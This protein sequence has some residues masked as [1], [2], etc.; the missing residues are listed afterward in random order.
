MPD[1]KKTEQS[2]LALPVPLS[3]PEAWHGG[4]EGGWKGTGQGLP[5]TPLLTQLVP[6]LSPGQGPAGGLCPIP[7]RPDWVETCLSASSSCSSSPAPRS[8]VAHARGVQQHQRA[9]SSQ[10]FLY[11]LMPPPGCGTCQD[12]TCSEVPAWVV[13]TPRA[14]SGS[15][16][17]CAGDGEGAQR[18][19]SNSE[20]PLSTCLDNLAP[21]SRKRCLRGVQSPQAGAGNH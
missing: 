11:F 3:E 6:A 8:A 16:S 21:A 12:S 2:S 5:L 17:Q 19:S 15:P 4:T 13:C 1:R 9:S 7:A 14:L 10:H 20:T 18:T